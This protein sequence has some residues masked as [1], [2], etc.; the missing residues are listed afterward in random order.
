MSKRTLGFALIVVGVVIVAATILA[1]IV[2]IG[3]SMGFG[4]KQQLG[5]AIGVL[6]AL[7][8]VWLTLRKPSQ[9]Q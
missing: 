4:W 6:T 9:K 5:T 8:G 1:D 2:G 3:S 7:V